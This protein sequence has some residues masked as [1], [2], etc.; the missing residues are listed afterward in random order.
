MVALVQYHETQLRIAQ[1]FHKL[2]PV[3]L[4][5]SVGRRRWDVIA[6]LLATQHE[7]ASQRNV[8]V[9]VHDVDD[10]LLHSLLGRECMV[11]E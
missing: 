3:H 11:C 10:C 9:F 6:H 1:L 2:A 7:Y 8:P 4:V 5:A